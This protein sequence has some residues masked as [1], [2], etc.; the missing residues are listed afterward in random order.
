MVSDVLQG[1]RAL[2]VVFEELSKELD[3]RGR[4]EV[5]DF[6]VFK[7]RRHETKKMVVRGKSIVVPARNL[8]RFKVSKKLK[9]RLNSGNKRGRE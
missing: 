4:V 9:R 2:Q 7:V 3:K 8:V 5:R 1:R 6:G